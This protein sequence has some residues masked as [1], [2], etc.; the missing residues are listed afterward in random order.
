MFALV[1]FLASVQTE[2]QEKDLSEIVQALGSPDLAVREAASTSLEAFC[3]KNRR[4]AAD[5][6]KPYLD[7]PDGEVKARIRVQ[8]GFLEKVEECR[9]LLGAFNKAGLSECAGKPFAIFNPNLVGQSNDEFRFQYIFGWVLSET[10][11]EVTIATRHLST[12]TYSR[13]RSL[14]KLR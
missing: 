14:P 6:L 9:K 7:S 2:P 12:I 11:D 13:D 5:L 3:R 1:L 4:N 10:K 8:L